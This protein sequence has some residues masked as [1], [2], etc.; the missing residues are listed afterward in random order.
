MTVRLCHPSDFK[1]FLEYDPRKHKFVGTAGPVASEAMNLFLQGLRMAGLNSTWQVVANVGPGTLDSISGAYN[2]CLGRIQ[3]NES[4]MVLQLFEYPVAAENLTQGLIVYDTSLSIAST[5]NK[6]EA[7]ASPQITSSFRSFSYGIWMMCSLLILVISMLL[8]LR[9]MVAVKRRFIRDY[10]LFYAIAHLVRVHQMPDAGVTRKVLFICGSIFSL[11]VVHYFQTLIKTELVV[12][13]DPI[14]FNSYQDIIDRRAMPI[15]IRGMGYDEFFKKRG[16]SRARKNLWNYATHTFNESDMY[17]QLDPL[18]FLLGAFSVIEKK[19]VIIVEKALVPV[20]SS[21][22]CPMR[23]R[24]PSKVVE[25]LN[26]L[27]D[28]EKM[29]PILDAASFTE[30]QKEI[31]LDFARKNQKVRR[32]VPEFLFYESTDES[33]KPFSQGIVLGSQVHPL[34][35]KSLLVIYRRALETGLGIR[36]TNIAQAFDVLGGYDLLNSMVEKP[37]KERQEY[38]TECKSATVLRAMISFH[39]L[40]IHNFR[41]LMMIF[42][43]MLICSCF[44]LACESILNPKVTRKTNHCS[45]NQRT[46]RQGPFP[47]APKLRESF[48]HYPF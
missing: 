8:K 35:L 1:D 15:F 42:A 12:T 3:R 41:N 29:S 5:Y 26:L 24:N 32:S 43:V 34:L 22:G 6:I 25:T 11:V 38:V 47:Y 7:F 45:R 20:I 14:L 46:R 39:S 33:E 27:S 17:I 37:M 28:R 48:D 13:K 36:I 9:V 30:E 44:T 40:D 21:S 23:A 18:I 31:V 16:I 2:G 19:A 10:S 4:D